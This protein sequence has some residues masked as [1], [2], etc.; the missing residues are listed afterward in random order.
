VF[1]HFPSTHRQPIGHTDRVDE[2]RLVIEESDEVTLPFWLKSA[3]VYIN[4]H[5]LYD[6]ARAAASEE[7]EAWVSPPPTVV[8]PPS[9]QLLGGPDT[10]E[11]PDDPWFEDGTVAVGACGCSFPGCDALLVKID[12]TEDMVTWR[13]F[14]RHNRPAVRYAALGPFR[15]DR[16]DY[17][18]ALRSAADAFGA[19]GGAG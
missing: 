4:G 3:V 14:R 15:F 12:F 2:F 6:L 19:S 17:E 13:D 7:D 16:R 8:L 5:G 11:D 1:G 10:W 18:A 9:R